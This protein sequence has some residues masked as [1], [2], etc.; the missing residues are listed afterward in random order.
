[1]GDEP[2][3]CRLNAKLY[4]PNLTSRPLRT[5]VGM[6]RGGCGRW[7]GKEDD[8]RRLDPF[9]VDGAHPNGGGERWVVKNRMRKSGF[10]DIDGKRWGRG[11]G[12]T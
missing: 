11:K 6:G 8:E 4:P 10:K 7:K 12:G 2:A 9:Q 5:Y 1:M 3:P